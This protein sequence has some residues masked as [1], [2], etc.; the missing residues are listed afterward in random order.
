MPFPDYRLIDDDIL[1]A[2]NRYVI[3]HEP[4]GHFITALLKNDL[5]EA[6]GRA[7]ENNSAHMFHVVSYCYNEIPSSCWGSPMEVAKW[8]EIKTPSNITVPESPKE[9][10]RQIAMGIW[11]SHYWKIEEKK[12]AITRI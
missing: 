7:N 9:M 2:I 4:A 3:Q 6:F 5:K 12:R 11:N 1:V 8:L 10:L